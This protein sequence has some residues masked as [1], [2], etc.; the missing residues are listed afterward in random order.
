ML[1][2]QV[3]KRWMAVVSV[4]PPGLQRNLRMTRS[5][6]VPTSQLPPV[7]QPSHHKVQVAVHTS[8]EE[9]INMVNLTV[10][11]SNISSATPHTNITTTQPV[12]VFGVI[13]NE[14]LDDD[15]MARPYE[16]PEPESTGGIKVLEGLANELSE[17]L[18]KEVSDEVDKDKKEK[19][20]SE[21]KEKRKEKSKDGIRDKDRDKERNRNRDRDRDRDRKH[22][23]ESD[24]RKR[25]KEREKE[26]KEK[27]RESKPF[28]ET[29]VRDGIDSAEVSFINIIHIFDI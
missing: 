19:E 5:V 6:I 9:I 20:K 29:E 14:S 10:S 3:L 22:G 16:K 12:S 11:T 18:K 27:K 17:S 25:E 15:D 28:R 13:V 4:V 8:T 7:G 24:R 26:K 23:K 1:F 2:P 21:N